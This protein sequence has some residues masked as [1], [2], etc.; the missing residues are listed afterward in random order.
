[1]SLMWGRYYSKDLLR[2][3]NEPLLYLLLTGQD[4]TILF[5][6]LLANS[7]KTVKHNLPSLGGVDCPAVRDGN[8]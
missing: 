5:S 7:C 3:R 8:G 6:V 2:L 4:S 1:M